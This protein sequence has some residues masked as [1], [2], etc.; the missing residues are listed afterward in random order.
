MVLA[1]CLRLAPRGKTTSS[2]LQLSSAGAWP[3]M[4]Y[5]EDKATGTDKKNE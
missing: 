5:L 2:G 4:V 1:E 3:F